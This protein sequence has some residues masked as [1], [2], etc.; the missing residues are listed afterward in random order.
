ML[1]KMRVVVVAMLL[2]VV[3]G[4]G[5]GSERERLAIYHLETALGPPGEEGELRCGPPRACPGVV[6]QP[7]PREVRYEVLAEAGVEEDGIDRASA[8]AAGAVVTVAL[9]PKGSDDFARLTREV[10]RY[11]GRDQGWHHLALVVGDEI[12]AFPQVDFDAYPDGIRDAPG[13][14]FPAL[15][16]ADAR[17]LVRRLRGE[18]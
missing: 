9:T 3:L 4:C 12:V 13:V 17:A 1:R 11:G 8:E 2:L 18:G 14:Q 16:D 10:A 7:A 5:D 15:D 6:A